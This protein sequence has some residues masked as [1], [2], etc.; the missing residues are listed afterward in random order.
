MAPIKEFEVKI[1]RFRLRSH[2]RQSKWGEGEKLHVMTR[3]H[4]E[5]RYTRSHTQRHS[6]MTRYYWNSAPIRP[7]LFIFFCVC[8]CFLSFDFAVG[9]QSVREEYFVTRQSALQDYKLGN[10]RWPGDDDETS[11]FRS[12]VGASFSD[13]WHPE[14]A[15]VWHG[16]VGAS[17]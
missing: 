9:M 13:R 8:F 10:G 4:T 2:D 16:S 15:G 1:P 3:T 14:S 12:F 5:R 11:E 17:Q 7:S 6:T